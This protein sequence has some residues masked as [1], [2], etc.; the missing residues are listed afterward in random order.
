[1]T[2]RKNSRGIRGWIAQAGLRTK[3]VLC[4]YA[5]MFPI[6]I[7]STVYIVA[8]NYNTVFQEAAV[9]HAR[10]AQSAAGEIAYLQ[11]DMVDIM[12]YFTV[13]SDIRNVLMSD[14]QRLR[15]VSLF[16]RFETPIE[17]M[18]D[19]L[20]I[21]AQLSTVILYPENGLS[22]FYVSNDESVHNADLEQIRALPMYQ[23]AAQAMGDIVW[24]LAPANE[25]GFYL[26][27]RTDKIVAS[28]AIFDLSKRARLGFLAIS[29]DAATFRRICENQLLS[30]DGG[31]VVLSSSGQVM[32]EAG[33][34]NPAV[35]ERLQTGGLA[36]RLANSGED[37]HSIGDS[38]VFCRGQTNGMIVCY[39]SPK[40]GWDARVRSGLHVPVLMALALLVCTWPLSAIVSRA[41]SRS[42]K[43]LS[44]AMQKFREGDFSQQVKVRGEDE[45]G[46]MSLAFNQMATDVRELIEKN[47]VMALRERESELDALQAQIN[48]HF[49]YNA[50][51][52]LYWQA[53]E[54][55]L[56]ALAEDILALS[57][58]FRLLLSQGQS[59]IPVR[60]EV[61]LIGYYLQIQKM[62]FSQ[63]LAYEIDVEE[64]VMGY[65]IPKLTLQPFVENAIVH[66]LEKSVDGGFVKIRGRLEGERMVFTIQ[67]NGAGMRQED[68]DRML[69][70]G[71]SSD[72]EKAR[73]GH[74]AI[75]NIKE[76]LVL[77]YGKSAG[78][79]IRSDPSRGTTVRVT[80]PISEP[81]GGERGGRA[82]V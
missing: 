47:Y 18:R 23:S 79:D 46:Q 76:R 48:P 71:E 57:K 21:K 17:F 81:Q 35:A 68:A 30:P 15:D 80:L 7:A 65:L 39:F 16:W 20:A 29:M 51:D 40:V 10:A 27:N 1:M 53:E 34:S 33:R 45:I 42:T 31:I 3:I 54:T 59:E 55:G 67:D 2:T 73:I 41:L 77:R 56:G 78:L 75:G 52:S 4:I 62:R 24:T 58:L 74:F 11:Q 6:L 32:I 36:A 28:R 50:M 60:G 43:E 69:K 12:T 70:A 49:L 9:Q 37:Y 38:Y 13:N 8:H 14:A 63:K 22:P 5:V 66:G 61:E 82:P 19:I 26:R 64:A 25:P 44:A 72:Y